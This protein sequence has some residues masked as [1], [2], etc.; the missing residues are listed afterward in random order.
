MPC[1]K[2]MLYVQDIFWEQ[3]IGSTVSAK[4]RLCGKCMILYNIKYM[5]WTVG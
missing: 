3:G 1:G 2:C 4:N 5:E